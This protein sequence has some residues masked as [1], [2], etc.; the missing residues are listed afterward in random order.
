MRKRFNVAKYVGQPEKTAIYLNG[1]LATGGLGA[2][3]KAIG[4]IARAHGASQHAR[5]IGISRQRFYRSFDG[6]L[7]PQIDSVFNTLAAFGVQLMAKAK[8]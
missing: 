8:T 2:F 5:E 1:A 6:N 7:T 4:V 3:T